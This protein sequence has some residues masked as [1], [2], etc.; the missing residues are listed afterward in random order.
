MSTTPQIK[1]P[2]HDAI[3]V[4]VVTCQPLVHHHGPNGSYQ[5]DH[6]HH[7]HCIDPS[8]LLQSTA[9][10][11]LHHLSHSMLQESE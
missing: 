11:P 4:E 6:T 8:A 3:S 10:T 9:K 1:H 2:E 7:L 5:L